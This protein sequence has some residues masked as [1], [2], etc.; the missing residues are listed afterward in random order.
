MSKE[1][2]L[3]SWDWIKHHK[4]VASVVVVFLACLWSFD[5]NAGLALVYLLVGAGI[6]TIYYYIDRHEENRRK[7]SKSVANT[8]TTAPASASTAPIPAKPHKLWKGIAWVA[9]SLVLIGD[10]VWKFL[11]LVASPPMTGAHLVLPMLLWGVVG[12]LCL[13]K[14]VKVIKMSKKEVIPQNE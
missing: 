13:C 4:F 11:L 6:M 10:T 12:V 9:L 14:G 3:M 2:F 1:R 8:P 5:G 7:V